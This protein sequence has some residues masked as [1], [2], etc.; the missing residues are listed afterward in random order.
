MLS[1]VVSS[2]IFKVF[3][4]TRPGIE[5]RS[6]G[7]LANTL[8]A[9][10]HGTTEPLW[11]EDFKVS[12]YVSIAVKNTF[13]DAK[14][15]KGSISSRVTMTWQYISGIMSFGLTNQSSNSFGQIECLCAAKSWWNSYDP[16]Y[17]TNRKAWSRLCSGL[18]ASCK[19][20][21]LNQVN[22][23]LNQTGH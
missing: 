9:G 12:Q 20:R 19:V 7:P 14:L 18:V 17:Y 21:D 5:P 13:E 23:K 11:G 15:S 16:L 8:T 6:P 10:P 4:M 1:K 22:D 3:G 2:S